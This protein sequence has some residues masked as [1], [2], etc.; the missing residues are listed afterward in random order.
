MTAAERSDLS[1]DPRPVAIAATMPLSLIEPMA[2]PVAAA[3]AGPGSWGVK[4]VGADAPPFTGAGVKVAVLDTGIDPNHP[5][6]A[7]VTLT[8]R[9]FTTDGPDDTNGH[10]THCAGTIFGRDVG[11]MR[12]GGASGATKALIDKVLGAGG[13][14][15]E[16]L[17]A[18]QWA[19][20]EG[21]H[22][23]S[24]A[25][26]IDFPGFVNTLV[27]RGMPIRH[28]E[29]RSISQ[30]WPRHRLDDLG[31]L[32]SAQHFGDLLG[33]TL[34]THVL[35]HAFTYAGDREEAE[36]AE[37]VVDG[38]RANALV[39]HVQLKR[40]QIFRQRRVRR[41][42]DKPREIAHRS[43]THRLCLR[44]QAFDAHVF[45]KTLAKSWDG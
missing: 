3:S 29:R 37:T 10:G 17:K 13:G 9:S 45:K 7:D 12:I 16:L 33:D 14:S 15:G 4:A 8:P 5:A 21:A 44:A 24:M 35:L 43:K 31:H 28:A 42:P 20:E 11:S 19:A 26:G 1:C 41:A 27:A 32:F 25:L 22:I 40:P 38:R 34:A 30:T 2:T 23:I 36:N 39:R 18:I 6:F